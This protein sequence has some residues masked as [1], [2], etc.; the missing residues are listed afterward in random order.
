MSAVGSVQHIE[1]ARPEE[2]AEAIADLVAELS[3]ATAGLG[4]TLQ[5]RNGHFSKSLRTEP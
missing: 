3:A 5:P 4:N 1:P 2:P